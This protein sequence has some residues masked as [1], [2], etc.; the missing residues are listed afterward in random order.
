MFDHYVDT[1]Y[2]C[3]N[4]NNTNW[5]HNFNV[6]NTPNAGV[7]V[8]IYSLKITPQ[9]LFT[10]IYLL[11]SHNFPENKNSWVSFFPGK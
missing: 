7:T 10:E 8:N 1:R 6:S 5:N 11:S 4:T 9:Y 3:V 2:Y